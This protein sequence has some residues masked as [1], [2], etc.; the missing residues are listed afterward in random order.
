MEGSTVSYQNWAIAIYLITTNLK[1]VSSMQLHQD[2]KI[3]QKTAWHLARRLR[4]SFESDTPLYEGQ[5]ETNKTQI[6]GKRMNLPEHK[7]KE[8]GRGGV[9]YTVKAR[10]GWCAR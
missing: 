4:K 2:L 5:V 9:V 7:R 8:L 6:G 10:V 3:S 1:G